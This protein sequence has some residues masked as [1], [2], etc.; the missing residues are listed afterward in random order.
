MTN[1]KV[2]VESSYVNCDEVFDLDVCDD[3]VEGLSE[4]E[5]NM[6]FADDAWEVI[7]NNLCWHIEK[8]E[9]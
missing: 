4:D 3:E 1:L 9:N 7:K 2:V 8:E 6:K 5:L